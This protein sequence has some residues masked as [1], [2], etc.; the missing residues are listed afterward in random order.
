MTFHCSIHV[1]FYFPSTLLWYQ[2]LLSSDV[3]GM[4]SVRLS[5][6]WVNETGNIQYEF[7]YDLYTNGEATPVIK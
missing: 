4:E 6:V 5:I 3:V 2:V 1:C 7:E